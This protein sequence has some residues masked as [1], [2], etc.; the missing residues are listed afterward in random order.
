MNHNVK[1]YKCNNYGHIT[2]DCRSMIKYSTKENID[3]IYKKVQKNK[4]EG[5]KEEACGLVLYKNYESSWLMIGNQSK[6]LIAY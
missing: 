5:Q 6:S 2:H 4:P 3:I 1:C